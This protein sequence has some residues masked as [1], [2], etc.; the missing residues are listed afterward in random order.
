[1]KS[2]D[3]NARTHFTAD[4][5][6]LHPEC[7]HEYEGLMWGWDDCK[8]EIINIIDKMESKAPTGNIVPEFLSGYVA[9]LSELKSEMRKK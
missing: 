6:D 7:Q 8:K 3:E 9:A 4:Y 2:S 5:D 1:M